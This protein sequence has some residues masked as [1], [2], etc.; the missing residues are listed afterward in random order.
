MIATHYPGDPTQKSCVVISSKLQQPGSR[1]CFRGF[2]KTPYIF[3]SHK[4]QF[5]SAPKTTMILEFFLPWPNIRLGRLVCNTVCKRKLLQSQPGENVKQNKHPN[6]RVVTTK[7]ELPQKGNSIWEKTASGNKSNLL[8]ETPC[9]GT[10]LK[11]RNALEQ[12]T[13]FKENQSNRT[14]EQLNQKTQTPQIAWKSISHFLR[15]V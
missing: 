14:L 10:R 12:D 2:H 7:W 13:G 3:A 1:C 15:F 6:K 8:Q 9:R 4:V 5:S 11:V